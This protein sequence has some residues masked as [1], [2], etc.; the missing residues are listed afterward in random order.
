MAAGLFS[1][2]EIALRSNGMFDEVNDHWLARVAHIH[3]RAG[4]AVLCAIP[5]AISPQYLSAF[6]R[7]TLWEFK[8]QIAV[9]RTL[10]DHIVRD[11]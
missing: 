1:C 2:R 8:F 7:L 10:D 11:I 5:S 9:Q 6:F 4:G 3:N